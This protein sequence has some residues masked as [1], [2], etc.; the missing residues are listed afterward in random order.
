MYIYL[1]IY[2]SIY[3]LYIFYYIYPS[4][5]ILYITG[6]NV[7]IQ[8]E[9]TQET[10][11]TLACCGGFLEV[12][13][14]LVDHGANIELG[15]STPL[16]EAS[17]EGHIDIVK[18]LI[19]KNAKIDAVT[20]TMDSALTYACANGHTVIADLLISCGANVVSI[21]YILTCN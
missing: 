10:A 4:I 9:E 15:A 3:L 16:M 6:A 12:A 14:Y 7:N 17:Q 18:Y 8:T 1:S 21:L 11:L 20:N 2:L 19:S 13:Q 5:Y